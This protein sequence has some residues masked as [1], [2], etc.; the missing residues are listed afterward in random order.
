M[1]ESKVTETIEC[2]RDFLFNTDM[3]PSI[4]SVE[5][6]NYGFAL[7]FAV[8]VY[9]QIGEGRGELTLCCGGAMNME[10]FWIQFDGKY[11]DAEVSSGVCNWE[12]LPIFDDV[13]TSSEYVTKSFESY[14]GMNFK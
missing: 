6:I 7:A 1:D 12:D 10:H 8:E 14:S 13:N 9:N 3:K 5:D 4:D 2:V 11:Y